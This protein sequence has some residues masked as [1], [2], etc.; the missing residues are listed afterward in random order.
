MKLK[1]LRPWVAPGRVRYAV[2]DVVDVDGDVAGWLVKSGGAVDPNAAPTPKEKPMPVDPAPAVA[3]EP[4][5][6][7]PE[8]PK[9]AENKDAWIAYY[10]AVK[11]TEPDSKMSKDD[12]MAVVG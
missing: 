4:A 8:R 12:I 11:G 5:G 6:E 3:E 9:N 2:G 10:R 7:V 1:M